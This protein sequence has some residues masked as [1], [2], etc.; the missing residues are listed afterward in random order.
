MTPEKELQLLRR[1]LKK[2]S[3]ELETKSLQVTRS[4]ENLHMPATWIMHFR[5]RLKR[6]AAGDLR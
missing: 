1:E 5:N 2:L 4:A 3:R 6:L